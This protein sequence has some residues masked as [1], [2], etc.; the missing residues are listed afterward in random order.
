MFSVKMSSGRHLRELV[1]ERL[2]AAAEEIIT[3][4]EQTIDRYEEVIKHQSRLLNVCWS[5]QIK[6][7]RIEPPQVEEDQE[8]L[9]ISQKEEQ[10]VMKLEAN[11]FT[12]TLISEEN[13]RSEAEPNSEQLLSH[14]STGTEIQDEEG[15]R[16]VDSGSTKEE[17]EPKLKKRRLKTGSQRNS[18]DDSLTSQTICENE[19]DAPQLHDCMKEEVLAVH[20]LWNQ[21]RNASLDQEEQDAVQVKAEETDT[22]MVTPIDENK[23]TKPNSEPLFPSHETRKTRKKKYDMVEKPL[24]CD[25]CGKEFS[26]KR[27]L[28]VHERIHTGEKPFSCAICWKRFNH[29]GNW[30]KH[31]RTHT[32]EKPYSCEICGRSFSVNNSLKVHRKRHTG[33]KPFSCEICGQRFIHRGGLQKHMRYHTGENLF[34]CGVCGQTFSLRDQLKTHQ[35]TH[36]GEKPFCCRICGQSFTLCANLTTHVRAHTGKKLFSC[37]VC[38]RSFSQSNSLKTHLRVHTGEKPFTCVVCRQ[39]FAQLA[40]L[41]KHMR[42]IHQCG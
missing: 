38:R 8:E 7:N 28:S 11:T 20:Q 18:D 36:M 34:S 23:E 27:D 12:V 42:R 31:L 16:H 14:N 33:E 30:K 25:T 41:K 9:H 26:Q 15:S 1:R 10:L 3:E 19:M 22:F 4:F 24:A 35:R 32:G 13:Q 29:C 40:T 17:E 39:S 5:P 21:E 6:V 2:A 37:G